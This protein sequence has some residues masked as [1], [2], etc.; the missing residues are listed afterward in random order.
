MPAHQVQRERAQGVS[1]PNFRSGVRHNDRQALD[2]L[3]RITT[4]N[5]W[6]EMTMSDERMA[7]IKPI[8]EGAFGRAL[9]SN[10]GA[11]NLRPGTAARSD[12]PGTQRE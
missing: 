6:T 11:R 8:E 9:S 7:L 2:G 4:L 12:I 3:V 5:P 10:N 1:E